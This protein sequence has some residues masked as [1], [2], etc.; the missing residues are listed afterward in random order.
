[1]MKQVGIKIEPELLKSIR[2]FAKSYG[3]T[4]SALM[5]Q[6]TL[7]YIKARI[8]GS[9][10]DDQQKH[11]RGCLSANDIRRKKQEACR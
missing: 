2:N 8:N 7:E 6:A 3:T 5:R 4:L 11:E 9:Y 1:M 10:T